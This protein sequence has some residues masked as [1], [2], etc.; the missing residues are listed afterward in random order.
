MADYSTDNNGKQDANPLPSGVNTGIDASQY[1]RTL[2]LT[3]S[4][5]MALRKSPAHFWQWMNSPP[6]PS[7][8][9]M[10][11]GTAT[12]TLVF[13]PHKWN[14]EIKVIPADAPKKPTATQLR[15]EEP[16]EKA[17]ASIQW[18]NDFYEASKGKTLLTEEQEINARGMA[19]A[20]VE[21]EECIPYL[22]HKSA[23]AEL[24][25]SAIEQVKG[26]DI[27]CKMRC[28][29][30][31]MDGTIIV[32]LKTTQDSSQE[33]FARKFMSLGYWMQAA[34]YLKTAQKAGVPVKRFIFIAVESSP[35][36]S[37]AMYELDEASLDKA[38]RIRQHLLETLANCIAT[39]KYPSHSKGINALTMPYWLT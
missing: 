5:L 19:K 28:D 37:V 16:S 2:G 24:S 31:T 14:D 9:A 11:L 30:L 10:A 35:P 4:G 3:K 32:D 17:M 38:F 25:I 26:L 29:L 18:W 13:E 15:A 34:H 20:V 39:G 33:E 27:A 6:E 22:K 7:T 1:H 36:Y 23:Q 8:Q 12:H 21:N